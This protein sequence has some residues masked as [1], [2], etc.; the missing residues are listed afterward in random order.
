M[1]INLDK[2][3]K[4]IGIVL[5]K[6]NVKKD[7]TCQVKFAIDRSGSM[8][9]LYQNGTVQNVVERMLALGLT[10]DKDKQIDIWA[11]HNDSFSLPSVNEKNVENYV[12]KVIEKKVEYGGT[13]Y[14]PVLK[15]MVESS[16]ASKGFLGFGKKELEPTLAIFITDGQNS[17]ERA[18]SKILEDIKAAPSIYWLLVG[19]GRSSFSFIKNAADKLDNVG[20]VA[21]EDIQHISDEKLYEALLSD[22]LVKWFEKMGK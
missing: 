4:S 16:K 7:I 18:A 9:D 5:E 19:I 12:S 14:A 17:D 10:F 3:V 1:A 22:E 20:F 6:R 15:E 13:E 8:S 2:H 21:I 11:F